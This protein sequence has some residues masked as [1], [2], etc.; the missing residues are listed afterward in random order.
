MSR[1]A[2]EHS[3]RAVGCYN[4]YSVQRDR[5]S[6]ESRGQLEVF[7]GNAAGAMAVA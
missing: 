1:V 7:A 6:E 3:Y 5:F 2:A 4:L